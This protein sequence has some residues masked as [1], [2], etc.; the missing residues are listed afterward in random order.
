MDKPFNIVF[1]GTPGFSVE[2]LLRLHQ[3]RHTLSLV[4]TQPDRPKGRG[5]KIH[6]PPVKTTALALG[7][8]VLQPTRMD[9][10][11]FVERLE[12]I[13][14]D[15]LVVIAY[16]KILPRRLLDL[17]RIGAVNLHASLLPKYR[18]PAPIQW[19]VINGEKE[20]GVTAMLMAAG[21]DTGDILLAESTAIEPDDTSG[22]LHD[23]LSRLGAEVLLKALEDFGAG[24]IR[25]VPQDHDLATY[26]PLLKKEDGHIGWSRSAA[27]IECLI[28]GMDPWPGAFV[29][30]KDHRL[31]ILKGRAVPGNSPPSPP[32]TVLPGSPDELLV[33]AG[34]GVLS[35][36]ELQGPSGK[37]LKIHEFL[38][39]FTVPPGTVLQ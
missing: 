16:G 20:T 25:P 27:S 12:R 37:R 35:I 3:S 38:R 5:R 32:G 26:A 15:Y 18:G 7:L 10:P 28:R 9:D 24:R 39:G 2:S 30:L 4:V 29:Y 17:P 1:M 31:K 14:P 8:E 19:A 22:S 23:R 33:A 34:T 6:P 13:R 11:E 36:L 21:L